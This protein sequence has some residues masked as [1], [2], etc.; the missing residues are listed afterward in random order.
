MMRG[1]QGFTLIEVM[2]ALA[3]FAIGILAAQG[4]QYTSII[5]NSSALT[6]TRAA[7]Q[8]VDT[9]ER[10]LELDYH[11]ALLTGGTSTPVSHDDSEFPAVWKKNK[12]TSVNWE[13][14][15]DTPLPNMKTIDIDIMT[16]SRGITK[17]VSYTYY[18]AEII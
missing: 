12:H 17:T 6:M 16:Q 5:T 10:L 15:N 3:V 9:V 18:K 11:D 1:E 2:A 13:V 8:G 4:M 14:R 7:G